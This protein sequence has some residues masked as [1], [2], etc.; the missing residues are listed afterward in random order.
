MRR[1]QQT[2]NGFRYLKRCLKFQ[3]HIPSSD[4]WILGFSWIWE[5]LGGLSDSKIKMMSP[6]EFYLSENLF[7][8]YLSEKQRAKHA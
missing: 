3:L 6:T 5:L 4:Q 2:E 7:Y 1:D 8:M